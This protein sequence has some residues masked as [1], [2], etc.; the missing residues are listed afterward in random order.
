ME[1]RVRVHG[2]FFIPDSDPPKEAHLELTTA[3]NLNCKFCYRR[4]WDEKIG[5]M[6]ERLFSRILEELRSFGVEDLWFSGWGEPVLHPM[7]EEFAD[8]ASKHFNLGMITNGTLL[9][10]KMESIKRNFSWVFVSVDASDPE[11][12]KRIRVGSNLQT[13]GEGVRRL[14][15]NGVEVW[16]STVLL[17]STMEKLPN[18]VVWASEVGARGMLLSNLIATHPSIVDEQIH[19]K[20]QPEWT[21]EVM[22]KVRALSLIHHIRVVE[23][24]FYYKTERRCPFVEER[25]FPITYDGKVA[26]CLFTLHDYRAWID[27][28]EVSVK[29]LVFGDLKEQRMRD[30]WWSPEYVTFRARVKLSV[31]PSCNDCLL[32]DG[33]HIA[34]SNE[35][36]CWGFSPTCSFCPYYRGVVQCPRSYVV[37]WIVGG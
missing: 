35:F 23:P 3:C 27:G 22:N 13:V 19:G 6:D 5:F 14:A 29:Q 32:W 10:E 1:R 30:I 34:T 24:Y 37:R 31:F 20:V 16:I 18:L 11:T 25:A 4:S 21:S 7:F 2:G 8:R 15:K 36:D 26:P 17:R 12:Y 9:L 33:C 28:K